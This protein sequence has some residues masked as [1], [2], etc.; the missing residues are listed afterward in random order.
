MKS[1]FSLQIYSSATHALNNLADTDI[2]LLMDA[3][4]CLS[5]LEVIKADTVFTTCGEKTVH[6]NE[7]RNKPTDNLGIPAN[8]IP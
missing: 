5:L 1:N 7:I 6:G 8:V 4:C 2:D 3:I